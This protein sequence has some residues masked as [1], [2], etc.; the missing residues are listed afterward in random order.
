M[1]L[2]HLGLMLLIQMIWGVNFVVVKLGLDHMAP[3]FFVALRFSLAAL[4]LL[5]I[6][7]LPRTHLKQVAFLSVTLGLCTSP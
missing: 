1:K 3:L 2:Q 7:G 4:F 5:P 6:A